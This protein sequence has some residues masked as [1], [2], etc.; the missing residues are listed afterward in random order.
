MTKADVDH[1][2]KEDSDTCLEKYIE[3]QKKAGGKLW[4]NALL[5]AEYSGS[6]AQPVIRIPEGRSR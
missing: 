5:Y 6:G 3:L 2:C 4:S 1:I